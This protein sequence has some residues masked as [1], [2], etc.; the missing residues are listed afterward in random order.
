MLAPSEDAQAA[1]LRGRGDDEEHVQRRVE[2]GRAEEAEGRRIAHHVIVNDSL[3]QTVEQLLAIIDRERGVRLRRA[4]E[5][6]G[7]SRRV[8]H[9]PPQWFERSRQGA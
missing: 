1:R 4:F 5:R 9:L 6:L 8:P 3:E 2:L 7:S